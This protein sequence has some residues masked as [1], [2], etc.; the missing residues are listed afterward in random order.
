MLNPLNM[1]TKRV[2]FDKDDRLDSF[3]SDSA[4]APHNFHLG[5]DMDAAVTYFATSVQVL[6]FNNK[7][8]M[9]T[10]DFTQLKKVSVRRLFSGNPSQIESSSDLG[11]GKLIARKIPQGCYESLPD[12]LEGTYLEDFKNKIEFHYHLVVKRVNIKTKG[13]AKIFLGKGVSELSLVSN[14]GK[15]KGK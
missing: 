6:I 11:D 7:Q 15:L 10:I 5:Q 3:F 12:I 8:K 2:C 4:V 1:S 9:K 13:H 14:Q